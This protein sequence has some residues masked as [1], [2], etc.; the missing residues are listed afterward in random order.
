[1]SG[2]SGHLGLVPRV[3]PPVLFGGRRAARL[4]ERNAMVYRRIWLI[5]V[6][7]FFEPLFY[8]L[9]IGVGVGELA[10]SAGATKAV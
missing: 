4:V 10:S 1:M 6:S 9:S 8:L 3:V 5:L 7:G 2:R